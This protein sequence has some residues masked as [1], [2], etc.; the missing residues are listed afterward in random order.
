MSQF[1]RV[2]FILKDFD[3]ESQKEADENFIE[4]NSLIEQ[5]KVYNTTSHKKID[6]RKCEEC[7]LTLQVRVEDELAARQS[8]SL[9]KA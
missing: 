9:S 1:R 5:A 7:Y 4:M 2:Y 8:Y 3:F 6:L